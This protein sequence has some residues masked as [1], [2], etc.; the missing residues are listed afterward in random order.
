MA[1]RWS[2]LAKYWTTVGVVV[3]CGFAMLVLVLRLW[4]PFGHREIESKLRV[5]L[6]ESEVVRLLG[7]EPALTYNRESAP[8]D[9]YVEGW[10]R[11]VRPITHRVLIFKLGEPICYVWLDEH[12]RVEDFF[13]GGS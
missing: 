2:M 9:Y 4:D 8:A 10:S 11:K 7:E 6:T 3:V 5:G 13:V 1:R 12:G